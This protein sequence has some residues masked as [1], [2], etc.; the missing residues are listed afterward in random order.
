[1]GSMEGSE[2]RFGDVLLKFGG[3]CVLQVKWWSWLWW[4]IEH[5]GRRAEGGISHVGMGW[6]I[7]CYMELLAA[8]R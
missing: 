4:M 3:C 1:M 6:M 7:L 8:L 5:R 2:L